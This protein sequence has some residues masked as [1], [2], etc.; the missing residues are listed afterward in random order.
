M[1]LKIDLCGKSCIAHDAMRRGSHELREI[2][3]LG[4]RRAEAF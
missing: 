2:L 3:V 1:I 4:T